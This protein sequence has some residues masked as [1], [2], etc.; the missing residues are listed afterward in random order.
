MK[1]ISHEETERMHFP[2]SPDFFW[3]ELENERSSALLMKHYAFFSGTNPRE[4]WHII[5]REKL[6]VGECEQAAAQLANELSRM[7]AHPI[8]AGHYGMSRAWLP[9]QACASSSNS[10]TE[11]LKMMALT[12][13]RQVMPDTFHGAVC[14]DSA[15]DT[16]SFLKALIAYPT[17]F[18]YLSLYLFSTNVPLVVEIGHH[19]DVFFYS[20]SCDYMPICGQLV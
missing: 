3:Q 14:L 16:A 6:E 13:L 4:L 10:E 18:S 11:R 7:D 9:P 17:V 15:N 20:V 1:L 8:I 19:A 12:Y 2:I 5:G